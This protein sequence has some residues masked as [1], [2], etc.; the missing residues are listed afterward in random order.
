MGLCLVALAAIIILSLIIAIV[1]HMGALFF[2]TSA[3]TMLAFFETVLLI[4]TTLH[5]FL[6]YGKTPLPLSV[7]IVFVLILLSLIVLNSLA[8]AFICIKQK[9]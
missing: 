1:K 6:I 2:F 9:S 8:L 3:S 4:W 5:A 7:A